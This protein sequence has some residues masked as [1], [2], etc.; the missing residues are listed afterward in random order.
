MAFAKRR[1]LD[2]PTIPILAVSAIIPP[3]WKAHTEKK[4]MKDYIFLMHNDAEAGET[5]VAW[6]TCGSCVQPRNLKAAAPSALENA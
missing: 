3:S 6:H 2:W 1:G 5:D 4:Q